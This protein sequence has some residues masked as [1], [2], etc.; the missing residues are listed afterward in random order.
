MTLTEIE[1]DAFLGAHL[2]LL[3][4]VG[5][6]GRL[7]SGNKSYD[8]FLN[9]S[10]QD[11]FKCREFLHR[12]WKLLDDYIAANSD[13]LTSEEITILSGFKKSISSKFVI[14]KCLTKHAIFIDTKDNKFYAVKAL[15]NPFDDLIDRIPALIEATLLPFSNHI[16]YDGFIKV[17]NVFLGPGIISTLNEEYKKANK[18]NQILTK[19]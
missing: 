4:Y 18:Q 15:G 2:G 10:T 7:I 13:R 8:K 16:V 3:Y 6:Q 12:N 5:Q 14:L 11:K 1:Y 19:F 17:T 9:L